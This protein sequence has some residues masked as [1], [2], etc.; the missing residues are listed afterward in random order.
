V[1]FHLILTDN[2]NLCC[3]Y[4]RAKAFESEGEGAGESVPIDIDPNLP[5]ELT[6]DLSLLYEFLKK[7]PA[8]TLT[9]YGGEPLL[10]ADLIDRIVREAP[11]RRFMI[12]TN[13]LLLDRLDP[14]I[15]NRL[16]TILV[17]VDGPPAL[18]DSNRGVGTYRA[19]MENVKRIRANGFENEIIARM[20]VTEDTDI[21]EAVRWL[22]ENHD[23]SFTSIHWQL[24]ANFSVDYHRRR[25][26]EWVHTD[27]N[28]GVR[29]LVTEWVDRM[30]RDG[31]VPRWYPFLDPVDD[32]LHGKKSRLRCGSGYMNYSIMTDGHI[33]PCPVMAGMTKYYVGHIADADPLQLETVDVGGECRDCRI[34]DF[35]GGRC[36][37]SNIT[38]PWSTEERRLVCETIENLHDALT[39]AIPRVQKLISEDIISLSDFI[40]E[41]YNGCEIIP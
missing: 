34:R 21:V 24:D 26:A 13:G 30:E 28:P 39:N 32:L 25:F 17:S 2:C 29:A 41:K 36:L 35:C 14:G 40:H 3:S 8:P 10:R 6:V 16:S 9:F 1:Y 22:A 11:V 19:V 23:H 31:E 33:A 5:A 18:T 20:T 38:Q 4:C 37:Y 12:Q 15:I 27:Y 7:D